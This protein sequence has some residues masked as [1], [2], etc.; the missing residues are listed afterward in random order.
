M[1]ITPAHARPEPTSLDAP[2]TWKQAADDVFVATRAGE[3]A[4]FI[5][6]DVHAHIVHNRHS[7]RIG[8]YP[9]LAAARAALA[10]DAAPR[11]RRRGRRRRVLSRPA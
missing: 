10:G 9:T 6:V 3:F 2:L 8:S 5:T 4:G 7:R 11:P 1:T